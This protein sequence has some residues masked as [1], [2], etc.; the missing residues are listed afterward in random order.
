LVSIVSGTDEVVE[1]QQ[2]LDGAGDLVAGCE[3]LPF[4]GLARSYGNK[5]AMMSYRYT[6][7]EFDAET[8]LYNYRARLYDAALRRFYTPDPKRQF[9]SPYVYVG[10][11]PIMAIDPTG[12]FS[13]GSFF[14]DVSVACHP[15]HH[16]I[17]RPSL[18]SVGL[19]IVGG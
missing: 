16:P 18:D 9:A 7:Q 10:D 17:R 12:M 13:I 19:D 14:H 8:G 15:R 6:G 11:D 4:G 2:V 3:Y 1:D 5:P